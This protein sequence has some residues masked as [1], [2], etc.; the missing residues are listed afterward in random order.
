MKAN[1]VG[2]ISEEDIKKYLDT[3]ANHIYS[4]LKNTSNDRIKDV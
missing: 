1:K 3:A 2:R 4:E